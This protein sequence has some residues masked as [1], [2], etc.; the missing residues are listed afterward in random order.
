MELVGTLTQFSA[1]CISTR[2]SQARSA[3]RTSFET[4]RL[5]G[6]QNHV[7]PIVAPLHLIVRVIGCRHPR[8]P[9]SAGG[10]V[11][12]R[13]LIRRAADIAR[14]D[15][16]VA[17]RDG[18]VKKTPGIDVLGVDDALG[19][20]VD[21][22]VD[23]GNRLE[24][25]LPEDGRAKSVLWLGARVMAHPL[26]RVQEQRKRPLAIGPSSHT[27]IPLIGQPLAEPPLDLLPPAQPAI[28]HPHQ[29][30]MAEGVA[31]VLAER[32]FSRRSDVGEDQLG[33]RL[34]GK[35]LEVH[36]VPG[37]RGRSE[38][39]GRGAQ[40]RVGVEA[41]AKAVGIVLSAAGIL[42]SLSTTRSLSK[43]VSD[44]SPVGGVSQ[45]TA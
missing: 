15:N 1:L 6:H 5:T 22:L 40:F 35:A 39:A 23:L 21:H 44:R 19:D 28:V 38:E 34:G 11:Q 31:V 32:A 20:V 36:A 42:I 30:A 17:V 18:K 13:C 26:Q 16:A 41:N 9:Q 7:R 8:F 33:C 14:A 43:A 24:H 3:Q 4:Q 45:T 12:T 27:H 29:A 25:R 37:G 10:I 2:P